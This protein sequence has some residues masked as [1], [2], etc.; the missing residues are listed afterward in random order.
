MT[1]QKEEIKLPQELLDFIKK[2]KDKKGYEIMILHK[3]QELYGYIP[4]KVAMEISRKI[5]VPLARIYGVITFYHIFKL[6]KPGK[7]K[8]QVCMGTA[9]YLKGGQDILGEIENILGTGVNTT[10]EDGLFSIEI[11]RCIGCCGIAPA[12]M[13]NDKVY[14][15][16]RKEQLIE[17]LGEYTKLEGKD[18]KNDKN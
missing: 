18:M 4:R 15:N 16:L 12:M 8:I 13:I 11:V 2:N 10:T 6:N 3:V 1:L 9:C 5:N 7:Y 14:G 17:I